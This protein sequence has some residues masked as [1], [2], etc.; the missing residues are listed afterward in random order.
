MEKIHSNDWTASDIF[1]K[2]LIAAINNSGLAEAFWYNSNLLL[3]GLNLA[4]YS[5]PYEVQLVMLAPSPGY[6][7][8]KESVR[9]YKIHLMPLDS[10]LKISL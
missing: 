7:L 5:W 10:N 2:E 4:K 3:L 1:R 8:I 9:L 6:D